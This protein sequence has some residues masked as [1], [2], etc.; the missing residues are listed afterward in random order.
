MAKRKK[1]YL[2]PKTKIGKISFWLVM[3]GL[4]LLFVPYWIAMA[5]KISMPPASGFLSIGLMVIF[6]I[7]SVVAIIKNKDKAILLFVSALFGLFG[8]FFVLG[9]FLVPH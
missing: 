7:T 4:A 8:I 9:E 2:M 6:G 3:L 1:I 5:F